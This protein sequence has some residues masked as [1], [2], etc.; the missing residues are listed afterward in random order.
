MGGEVAI[1]TNGT[2]IMIPLRTTSAKRIRRKRKCPLIP[3]RKRIVA[4]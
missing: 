3:M 4:R 1:S 2:I